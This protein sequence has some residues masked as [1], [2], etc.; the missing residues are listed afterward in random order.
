MALENCPF[1]I[2]PYDTSSLVKTPKLVNLNYTNQDFWSLK[3]RLIDFTKEKFSTIFNDFV[4]SDLAI[5]L[6]ENWAFLADTL[7]FKMDQIANEVFIDTVSEVDNAFR[8]A[9]LV[10]FKPQPPIGARSK[11][12]ATIQEVLET[13][14]IIDT[15]VQIDITTDEGVR[16]IELYAAD[17]LDHPILGEPIVISAGSGLTT[18]IVGIE[19]QTVTNAAVGTG[20]TSQF[21]ALSAGPVIWNSIRVFV[22]GT[23]WKQV[24]FFTDS[25]PR[26]EF[27][28]EYD[29]NY[30]AF[31]QFGNNRS[32]MIPSD[33]SQI[34]MSFRVG[35]GTAGNIV[36]GAV[37]IQ[38]NYI[39]SGFDFRVP[40]TLRNYR[41]GE[42]GY[43]GDT[44][45]DIKRKLP[46]WI[47]TQNRIVS[48][49]DIET[50]ANQFATEFNGQIGKAK[51]VLRNHGCAA[52]IIDL[53]V[54]T[55][56]GEDGLEPSV[57]GLKVELQQAIA[58]K[59]MMTESFC[60]KDG[61][62]IEVDVAIDLTM[63]KFYR[64]FEQEF[65]E[66]TERRVAGFFSLHNWDYGKML[67]SV[68]I[69]KALSDIP[70]IQNIE[71]NLQTDNEDNSGEVVTTKFYEI[72]RPALVEIT[73]VYE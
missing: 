23:E 65:K 69:V 64:K 29:P 24:D 70:E 25:Q 27:R 71:I 18:S 15:P 52:N 26:Q 13:D 12:S 20:E 47:R 50:F 16:F 30:N 46:P 11:W 38:K 34:L 54:L 22:D 56:N 39:V 17:N 60:I 68:D 7:S 49:D 43:A 32:G 67:N 57:N 55:R 41:K 61:V 58:D 72:I 36:T 2:T 4:E 53:Y 21:I 40:V 62:I 9:M 10:G 66:R 45:D 59:K 28:V 8:L 73:F 63:D 31:I 14:L 33:G 6:I 37:E 19:G 3:A 5:M 35:G 1:D 51:G 42:F 44:L 48:N